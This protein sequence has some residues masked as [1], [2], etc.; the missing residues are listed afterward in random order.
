V[1]SGSA[2]DP[3]GQ[4]GHVSLGAARGAENSSRDD[5]YQVVLLIHGIRTEADWGPMVRSKLEVAGQIEVIPIKGC[6]D[7][8]RTAIAGCLLSIRFGL[9]GLA[10]ITSSAKLDGAGNALHVPSTLSRATRVR[11][12][13][14]TVG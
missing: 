10:S 9:N 7:K 11:A 13:G 5:S 4:Q 8:H 1:K 2:S 3:L 6:Q 12:I 14:G